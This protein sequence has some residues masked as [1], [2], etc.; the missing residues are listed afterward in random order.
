MPRRLGTLEIVD[1]RIA[2]R[3]FLGG[4]GGA[5]LLTG[6]KTGPDG[7]T[8][9]APSAVRPPEARRVTQLVSARPTSEGAGVR[10]AR[11]IGGPALANLD[12][13]LLLDD[14]HSSDPADYAR[15]FPTHPHRGFETVTIMIDGVMEHEDSL[16]NRGLLT[17][18][19]LQW[20]TA[21][22]GIVHSEMPRSRGPFWGLQ[23]W[24][25][26]PARQKL[27]APRYQDIAPG[28]VPE[29][30]RTARTRLLAGS[31]EGERGPV[32]GV[33]VDP[34]CLDVTL[35]GTAFEFPLPPGHTAFVYVLAG[36]ARIGPD[37][38]PASARSLAV[39]GPGHL[40][41][42]AAGEDASRVLLVAAAPLREPIARRGPFVM[43]T[44]AELDQAVRDYQ[45][46]TLL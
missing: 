30:G 11:S 45:A 23:L 2:R 42:I 20:M 40:A 24:V 46:G 5:A 10:L 7:E 12:P 8:R 33:T 18:G 21:G 38:T 19:G 36:S 17:G 4:L 28:R 14:I 31:L 22:K 9:A 1:A 35:G 29:V 41:R 25:N 34:I 27:T 44:D 6:C 39:L 26:L 15:G 16:G 43:N 3:R 32:D 13:F 37:K